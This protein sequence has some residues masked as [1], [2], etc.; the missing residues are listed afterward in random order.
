MT[1]LFDT[2]MEIFDELI[3]LNLRVPYKLT[4]LC[5]PHLQ[6]TKGNIVNVFAAPMRV[7]PGFLPYAMIRDALQRFTNSGGL[8]TASV[9]VRMNAVR[10]G[11]TRTNFLANLNVSDDCVKE[12]YKK[13][14][15]IVPNGVIIEPEEMAKMI[16]FAAS[17]S[18]PN[19]SASNLILDGASSIY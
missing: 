7:T 6:N 10:P 17:D 15:R 3:A 13:L 18:C 2:S 4:K 1:D 11:I 9:G 8:E 5:L 12:A 19:L 16:I 14:A